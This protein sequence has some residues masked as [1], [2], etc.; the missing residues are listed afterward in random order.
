MRTG[1]YQLEVAHA[2]QYHE[3]MVGDL[4]RNEEIA[5]AVEPWH[6]VLEQAFRTSWADMMALGQIMGERRKGERAMD[7]HAC[8]RNVLQVACDYAEPFLTLVMEPEGQG[9]DYCV[10][11][12]SGMAIA[13]RWGHYPERIGRVRRN[14]T[15]RTRLVQEQGTMFAGLDKQRGEMP[16]ASVV[17]T[18]ED[19]Y[20][21]AGI[22]QWWMSRLLLAREWTDD[23]E[24]IQEIAAYNKPSR[25]ETER[26]VAEPRIAAKRRDLDEL[27]E[28]ISRLR[29]QTG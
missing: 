28:R 9:L 2:G 16:L 12:W 29:G 25:E 17:Y 24:L 18:V 6:P 15:D 5:R 13:L 19:D 3:W 26:A 1:I 21:E 22:E 8:V 4:V 11:D 7:M 20:S 14:S 27:Q 10:L 23:T